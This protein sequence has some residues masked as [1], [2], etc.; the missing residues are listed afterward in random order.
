MKPRSPYHCLVSHSESDHDVAL[1][2]QRMLTRPDLILDVDPFP[3]GV[4]ITA[5]LE[6]W[7]IHVLLFLATPDSVTSRWCR[8]ELRAAAR[9]GIPM[10][11]ARL[12]GDMAG[13]LVNRIYLDLADTDETSFAQRVAQLEEPLRTRAQLF[14]LVEASG[15]DEFVD[16]SQWAA[17]ELAF[18]DHDPA[19]LAEF[20]RSIG[21]QFRRSS[22]PATQAWLAKAL[23]RADSREAAM[24][25][26]QFL[27]RLP[28]KAHAFVRAALEDAHSR[29]A[30]RSR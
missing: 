20:V 11:A 18:G 9:R 8:A 24:L 12:R 15:P 21:R 29:T 2:I 16:D 28:T 25:V 26:K 4:D 7:T 30:W 13:A 6:T 19:A 10:V 5:R 1:R 27:Q 17:R 22:D 23:G 14:G 3:I